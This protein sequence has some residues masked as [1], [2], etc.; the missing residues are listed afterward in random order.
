MASTVIPHF[1]RGGVLVGETTVKVNTTSENGRLR[2]SYTAD[3]DCEIYVYFDNV[4]AYC[5]INNTPQ[6]ASDYDGSICY[7]ESNEI[8]F[9]KNRISDVALH[10]IEFVGSGYYSTVGST[11]SFR[12]V[13]KMNLYKDDVLN[14]LLSGYSAVNVYVKQFVK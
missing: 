2:G 3:R 1:T 11:V 9:G 14:I 10:N 7:V 6:Q 4:G 8:K 5:D 12:P 13:I